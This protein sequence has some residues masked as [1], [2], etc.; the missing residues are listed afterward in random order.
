VELALADLF[1]REGL[2]DL[3]FFECLLDQ[4]NVAIVVFGVLRG[5]VQFEDVNG[6][7]VDGV[8]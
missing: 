4:A 7:G 3:Q 1:K 6:A 8:D 2:V 5:K